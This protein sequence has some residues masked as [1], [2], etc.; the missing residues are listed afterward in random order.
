[1]SLLAFVP[2]CGFQSNAS[3]GLGPDAAAPVDASPADDSATDASTVDALPGQTAT[4]FGTLPKVCFTTAF[5]PNQARTL[6]SD[7]DT[8]S[9]VTCDTHN[10]QPTYCVVAGTG[11]TLPAG[12]TIRAYGTRPLVLLSTGSFELSGVLDVS[13]TSAA[14]AHPLGPGVPNAICNVGAHAATVNSGGFGGSFGG[15]G[16]DGQR[17][18]AGNDNTPLAAAAVAFPSAL[19]A[20]CPGGNGSTTTAGAAVGQG[21]AGGGAVSIIAGRLLLNGRLNASGAAGT[22]GPVAK[23]GGG[24]GGSGGMIIL[25]APSIVPGAAFAVFANGGGGGQGG[26]FEGQPNPGAG[27]PGTESTAPTTAGTGGHNLGTAGGAGG[28]GAAGANVNGT[29]APQENLPGNAGGGGGGGGAG[30]VHAPGITANI[31]P[32][33]TNP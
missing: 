9:T 23:S 15:K 18:D 29:S 11:I 27:Q 5:V 26:A 33:S 7:I 10:D 21:G 4:C 14:T 20:G 31:A 17:Q 22:G 19:R 24:G 6:T 3:P 12:T 25:D 1:M 13:S 30:F 16:G 28:N 8:T 2:A 32:P